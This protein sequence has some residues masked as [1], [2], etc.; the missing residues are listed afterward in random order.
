MRPKPKIRSQENFQKLEI[1]IH[2]M[3]EASIAGLD[4]RRYLE[5]RQDCRRQEE[6]Y[7]TSKQH[8][9]TCSSCPIECLPWIG[10]YCQPRMWT[11]DSDRKGPKDLP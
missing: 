7:K 5:M 3:A 4:A 1:K 9:V 11:C 10:R 8:K 2:Q 6:S